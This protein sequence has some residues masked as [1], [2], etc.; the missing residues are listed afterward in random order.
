[1]AP[2]AAGVKAAL[3]AKRYILAALMV[4]MAGAVVVT[5]FFVVLSP[6]RIHFSVT[7]AGR[8]RSNLSPDG[9]VLT[10]TL[11]ANNTSRRTAVTYE[12]MSIDVMIS[13]NGTRDQRQLL[14]FLAGTTV[15]TGMPLLQ[16]TGNVTTIAASVQLVHYDGWFQAVTANMTGNFTVMV[17]ATAWFKVGIARTRLYDIRVYCRP[18]PF[19]AKPVNKTAPLPLPVDCA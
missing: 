16:P 4:T 18:M 12:S 5:V 8:R 13:N 3:N 6:A 2:P 17:T 14:S 9:M 7:N 11:T 10:L 1:M 19:L 15:T